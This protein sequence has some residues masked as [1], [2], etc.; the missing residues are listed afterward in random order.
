MTAIDHGATPVDLPSRPQ[1]GQEERMELVPD[2][3]SL[4]LVQAPP[5]GGARA[6][7]EFQREVSPSDAGVQ[8]EEDAAEGCSIR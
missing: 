6:E 8:D 4:P 5:A 3:G 2:A 7:A 1:P